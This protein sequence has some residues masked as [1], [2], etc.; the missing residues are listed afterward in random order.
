MEEGVL[1]SFALYGLYRRNTARNN[2]WRQ[3]L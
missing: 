2:N 3:K 1:T